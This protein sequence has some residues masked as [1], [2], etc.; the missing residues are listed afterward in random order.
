MN[1][2]VLK[3]C[4]LCF[5]WFFISIFAVSTLLILITIRGFVKKKKIKYN[6]QVKSNKCLF[7]TKANKTYKNSLLTKKF[8]IIIEKHCL[9]SAFIKIT[10][11][12]RNTCH[13]YQNPKKKSS[14]VKPRSS[15]PVHNFSLMCQ[16]R[17]PVI[18]I[19]IFLPI[20]DPKHRN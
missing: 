11:N 4:K 5:L 9:T 17:T 2:I 15:K 19:N 7:F 18:C 20:F 6:S 1:K 13:S 3:S 12:I 10:K 8:N 14:L 16:T